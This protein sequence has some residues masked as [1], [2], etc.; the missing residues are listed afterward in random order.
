MSGQT[1]RW[2]QELDDLLRDSR[3]GKGDA[4]EWLHTQNEG[5]FEEIGAECARRQDLLP[6]PLAPSAHAP[7][8]RCL[9]LILAWVEFHNTGEGDRAFQVERVAWLRGGDDLRYLKR[10][11]ALGYAQAAFD[12]ARSL[13]SRGGERGRTLQMFLR[14]DG[15]LSDEFVE[16]LDL[17]TPEMSLDAIEAGLEDVAS[18]FRPQA[19]HRVLERLADADPALRFQVACL[20]GATPFT[21]EL[22]RTGTVP[23]SA[24]ARRAEQSDPIGRGLWLGLAARAAFYAGDELGVVRY[25]RQAFECEEPPALD[26]DHIWDEASESLQAMLTRVGLAP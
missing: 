1:M 12:L 2:S 24:V 17:V 9:E 7:E 18:A 14:G 15:L 3:L 23:A 10:Q 21:I 16:F 13:A 6:E 25:L 11:A 19:L 26:R 20:D 22:I 5:D 8:W 4:I